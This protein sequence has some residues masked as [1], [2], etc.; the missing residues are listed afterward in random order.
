MNFDQVCITSFYLVPIFSNVLF[1]EQTVK[2]MATSLT[3][4][5]QTKS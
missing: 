2:S 3:L 4:S 1:C 5:Y